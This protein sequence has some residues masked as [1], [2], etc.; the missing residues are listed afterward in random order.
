MRA[1]L[2]CMLGLFAATP[3][4]ADDGYSDKFRAAVASC[5]NLGGLSE[6]ASR[7]WVRTAF[8]LSK[9]GVPIPGSITLIEHGQGLEVDAE[10]A[11][12]AARRAIIR[13]GLRGYDLPIEKYAQWRDIEMTFNPVRM[14]IK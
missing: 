3:L 1:V 5:W 13:C 14:R 10:Q 9:D 12:E 11:F 7:M 2:A 6:G 8:E 4:A